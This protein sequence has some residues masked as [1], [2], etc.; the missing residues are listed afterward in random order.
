M[1]VASLTMKRRPSACD[2]L[3]NSRVK[4]EILLWDLVRASF[5]RDF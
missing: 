3:S 1:F 5:A 2:S 4:R